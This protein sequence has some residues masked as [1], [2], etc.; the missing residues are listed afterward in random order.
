MAESM[1]DAT[2]QGFAMAFK[3]FMPYLLVIAVL[4]ALLRITVR[5][6]ERIIDNVFGPRPR[7]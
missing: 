2:W 3:L 4:G 5:C 6:L 1:G 7:E